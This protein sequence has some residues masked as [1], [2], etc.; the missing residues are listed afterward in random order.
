MRS[1]LSDT[2][3][4][5]S[6]LAELPDEMITEIVAKL[7][8]TDPAAVF[9]LY[10][11]YLPSKAGSYSKHTD[12][13]GRIERIIRPFI[14]P[15]ALMQKEDYSG[16][17]ILRAFDPTWLPEEEDLVIPP[18]EIETSL[19]HLKFLAKKLGSSALSDCYNLLTDRNFKL[20]VDY[21]TLSTPQ[22]IAWVEK[23]LVDFSRLDIQ[24][25]GAVEVLLNNFTT[26]QSSYSDLNAD[27]LQQ[28][29][30]QTG[31]VWMQNL[32]SA[33]RSDL[34]TSAYDLYFKHACFKRRTPTYL[35]TSA[36]LGWFLLQGLA[37][38]GINLSP[39]QKA[40]QEGYLRMKAEAETT[41]E[42]NESY[43]HRMGFS[44]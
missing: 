13:A 28:A 23:D 8:V 21:A 43:D 12:K 25:N 22:A 32:F 11:A 42:E 26:L 40:L 33:G 30:A 35:V 20:K 34:A 37:P 10:L 14:S 17:R 15:L 29:L 24:M 19:P 27:A 41:K 9:K 1:G 38:N 4:S 3:S 36:G 6:S 7:F 18:Q 2:P 39:S 5:S 44:G 16:H 31:L